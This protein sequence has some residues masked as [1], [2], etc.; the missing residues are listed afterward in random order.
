MTNT[1]PSTD[2]LFSKEAQKEFDEWFQGQYGTYST[3]E[4]YFYTDCKTKDEE[5]RD[6][7]M[8]LWMEAAFRTG[9]ERGRSAN[10][11]TETS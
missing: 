9:Y 8:F 10:C 5:Y 2:Y 4:E 3:R 6:R 7:M 11:P 1:M